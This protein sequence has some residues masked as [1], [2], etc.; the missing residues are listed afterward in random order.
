VAVPVVANGEIWTQA[1]AQR[2]REA[3]GCE[4]LMLGRGMVCDPGL[5]AA[6]RRAGA[7]A[8]A[9]A[10]S[11]PWAEVLPLFDIFWTHVQ[12]QIAPRQQAGRLKQWLHLLSRR[13]PEAEALH[14]A[15]RTEPR[16]ERLAA[17]VL[18]TSSS[19]LPTPSSQA[20]TSALSI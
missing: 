3:S 10:P 6:V 14:L 17:A 2:C 7:D 12:S 15:W 20:E 9:F 5:A 4:H 19:R 1:D 16:A 18:Q 11:L 8:D 13:H